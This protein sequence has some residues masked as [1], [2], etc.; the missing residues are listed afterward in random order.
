MLSDLVCCAHGGETLFSVALAA[1]C[2]AAFGWT[3]VGGGGTELVSKLV[4]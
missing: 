4:L 3:G 2:L 1:D